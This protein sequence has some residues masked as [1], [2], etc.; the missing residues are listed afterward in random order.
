LAEAI[1]PFQPKR[2]N[3]FPRFSYAVKEKKELPTVNIIMDENESDEF[4]FNAVVLL[5]SIDNQILTSFR[6]TKG[7]NN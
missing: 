6:T 7:Q 4:P 2:F 5:K 3:R 1:Y